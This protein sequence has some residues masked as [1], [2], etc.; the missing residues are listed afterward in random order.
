MSLKLTD[1]EFQH[2]DLLFIGF[3]QDQTCFTCG[4]TA[5]FQIH[6]CDPYKE[7]FKREFLTGGIGIVEMLY[8]CNILALV[9][10]G[11]LPS[12]PVNKVMLWDDHQSTC[13]GEL[14]FKSEVKAVKLRRDKIVV[15]LDTYIY[16]YNF[17]K[18]DLEFKHE[19]CLNPKGLVAL[20]T[21]RDC[22]VA[23]PSSQRGHVKVEWVVAHKRTIN[24]NAHE[25]TLGCLSLNA[26]GTRLATASEKGTLIRIWDT[27][28][29]QKLHEVRRGADRAFIYSVSFSPQSNF[30]V[31]SSDKGTLHIFATKGA[32][33]S[34]NAVENRKSSW[35]VIGSVLPNYFNSEWSFAWYRGSDVPSICAFTQDNQKNKL[36]V[37]VV[38]ADGSYRKL[39]FDE[40][41]G[42]ECQVEEIHS[43]FNAIKGPEAKN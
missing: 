2:G 30:I 25:S 40:H 22:V 7:T 39:S 6:N 11:P 1:T 43:F 35:S 36:N 17:D 3:N 9:G 14:T 38:G 8:R 12:F 29:G 15:V 37:I 5:S 28:T 26:E 32:S 16:V 20:S 19:T 4:T 10:G 42:G 33:E 13:I 21:G 24:I 31:V 18:L 34:S 27:A 23:Y 41:K